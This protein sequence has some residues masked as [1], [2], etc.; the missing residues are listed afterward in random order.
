MEG[1]DEIVR[2]AEEAVMSKITQ[3][4]L[5]IGATNDLQRTDEWFNARKGRFTGSKMKELMSC[6]RSTSKMEWGRAEKLVDFGDAAKK[7]IYSKA[8]ERQRD[9]I[10]K[11]ASSSSMRYGTENEGAVVELLKVQ[12]PD[13]KFEDVGFIEFIEGVA[14]SSPDGRVICSN[15]P[16]ALE[17]KCATDWGGVYDRHEIA[18][19]QSNKDFWQMQAEML[20]I[21]AYKLMYVVAEP[22]ADIFEPDITDI[23][24][25]YV[26]ASPI[27][28]KALIQRSMIGDHAIRLFLDGMNFHDAIRMACS[29]FDFNKPI[30][31]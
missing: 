27:H 22:S 3:K 24:V 12:F 17:V 10:V 25:K 4:G 13:Y 16:M 30:L 19:D 5:D 15:G 7:Y 26:D 6:G 31:I 20:S 23:S 2:K 9:K 8:K 18:L 28:Q 1:F 29:E 11:T 21:K 14:G